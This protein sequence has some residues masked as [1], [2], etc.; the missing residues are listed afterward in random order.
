MRESGIARVQLGINRLSDTSRPL[1][2]DEKNQLLRN[3][4][5]LSKMVALFCQ[6]ANFDGLRAS[7]PG[8]LSLHPLKAMK[9]I[10]G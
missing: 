9:L 5:L 7:L 4:P 8:G 10:K 3:M 2:D 6:H 1:S